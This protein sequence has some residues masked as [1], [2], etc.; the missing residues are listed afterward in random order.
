V[1]RKADAIEPGAFAR[2]AQKALQLTGGA[3]GKPPSAG[4]SIY[5]VLM[6]NGAADIFLT[7]CTNCIAARKE[8]PELQ[9]VALPDALGVGADYGL[10]VMSDAPPNAYRFAMFV[11][12]EAGQRILASHGFSV[13]GRP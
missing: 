12:S 5:S 3:S 4:R 7:Y 1:F 6:S 13:P 8:D 9:M 2:L 11:G 10:T